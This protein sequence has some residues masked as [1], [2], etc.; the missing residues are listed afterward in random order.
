MALHHTTK[1]L[2]DMNIK[3]L[4]FTNSPISIDI[5][6]YVYIFCFTIDE[7]NFHVFFLFCMV[8]KRKQTNNTSRRQ[9]KKKIYRTNY[10]K[11]STTAAALDT[12]QR[13]I[14]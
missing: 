5:T 4:N 14:N 6:K 13:I 11:F 12:F 1:E 3:Q 2:T 10:L 8:E 7:F 9:T